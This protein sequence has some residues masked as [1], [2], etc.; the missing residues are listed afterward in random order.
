MGINAKENKMNEDDLK[1]LQRI[2]DNTSAAIPITDAELKWLIKTVENHNSLMASLKAIV[3][4]W[5]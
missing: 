1:R 2:K 5:T 3:S 4:I